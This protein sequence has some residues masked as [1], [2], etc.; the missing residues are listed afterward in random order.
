M[1]I[2]HSQTGMFPLPGGLQ[3]QEVYLW[4]YR[5]FSNNIDEEDFGFDN[6]GGFNE[7]S[8]NDGGFNDSGFN[9]SGFNDGG[10]NDDGFNDGDF[11]DGGFNDGGFNDGD[12]IV[13]ALEEESDSMLPAP[14]HCTSKVREGL[15]TIA[16]SDNADEGFDY[17]SENEMESSSEEESTM[18]DKV[19]CSE[20]ILN[21]MN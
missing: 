14:K 10:F 13:R 12:E 18:S 4:P 20:E 16:V 2:L 17:E 3:L 8:F 21:G 11:N 19:G 15:S 7:G 6:D 5:E 1:K 9:D